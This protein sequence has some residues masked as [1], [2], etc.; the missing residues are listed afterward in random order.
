MSGICTL[1]PL[2]EPESE[3]FPLTHPLYQLANFTLS[4]LINRT[5][6][7]EKIVKYY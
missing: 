3:S 5:V 2:G 4:L 1:L 7:P 6:V